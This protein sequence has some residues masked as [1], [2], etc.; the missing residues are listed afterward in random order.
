MY[1]EMKVKRSWQ[2]A[3]DKE[4]WASVIM[5]VKVIRRSYSRGIHK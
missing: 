1:E 3:V 5:E 4:E 2:K